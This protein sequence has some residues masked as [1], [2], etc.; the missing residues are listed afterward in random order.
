MLYLKQERSKG[1]G[2]GNGGLLHSTEFREGEVPGV[3]S[4]LSQP[5]LLKI[6]GRPWFK[7]TLKQMF[8]LVHVFIWPLADNLAFFLASIL[9]F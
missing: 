4:L 9:H 5:P 7:E 2:L 6:C 1:E 3:Q 8:V